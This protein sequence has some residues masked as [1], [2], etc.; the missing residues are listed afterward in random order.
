MGR[1]KIEEPCDCEGGALPGMD[2][3]MGSEPPEGFTV[4]QRCDTC[5]KFETDLEA[6]SAWGDCAHYQWEFDGTAEGVV[7]AIARP[8][9]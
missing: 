4:V 6:A 3:E 8:R 1:K 5:E 9:A 2:D 7:R